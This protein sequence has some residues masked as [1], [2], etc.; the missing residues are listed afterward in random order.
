MIWEAE[1]I[2]IQT[3]FNFLICL[4]CVA[5][6][7]TRCSAKLFGFKSCSLFFKPS[8]NYFIFWGTI[9]KNCTWL[10]INIKSNALHWSEQ[11]ACTVTELSVHYKRRFSLSFFFISLCVTFLPEGVIVGFWDFAWVLIHTKKQDLGWL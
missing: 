7:Y 5:N 6:L 10:L 11:L 3:F 4:T 1:W 8:L 2:I 9:K